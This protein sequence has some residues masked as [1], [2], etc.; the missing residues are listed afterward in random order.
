MVN[1]GYTWPK[2]AAAD[3]NN[4]WGLLMAGSSK[5]TLL[6]R[7]AEFDSLL[8]EMERER[9]ADKIEAIRAGIWEKFGTEGA[10]FISDM[11]SFSS[12]SRKFGVCHFLKLI[13]RA[14][15]GRVSWFVRSRRNAACWQQQW[16]W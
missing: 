1:P 7:H 3:N 8:A 2:S 10:V 14:D 12:T 15:S 4:F 16:Q 6:A 11:A 13:H 9:D 5:K